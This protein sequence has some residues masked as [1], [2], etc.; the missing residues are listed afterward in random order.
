M[1][2]LEDVLWKPSGFRCNRKHGKRYR[3]RVCWHIMVIRKLQ[4]SYYVSP[5]AF[6]H[7]LNFLC[8]HPSLKSDSGRSPQCS[9]QISLDLGVDK[10]QRE[11]NKLWLRPHLSSVTHLL[12]VEYEGAGSN[13]VSDSNRYSN[14]DE[15]SSCSLWVMKKT[16]MTEKTTK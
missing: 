13:P 2:C 14:K 6:Y 15:M 12:T 16:K 5:F 7:K 11:P 4:Q 9:P 10:S 3:K 1:G 8:G